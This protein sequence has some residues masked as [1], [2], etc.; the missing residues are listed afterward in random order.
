M[1]GR[2]SIGF[3]D[4]T[5]LSFAFDRVCCDSFGFFWCETGAL[6]RRSVHR[7][8]PTMP[9][10]ALKRYHQGDQRPCTRRTLSLAGVKLA[11]LRVERDVLEWYLN[12]GSDWH[13]RLDEALCKAAGK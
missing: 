13:D 6:K 1:S 7:A 9:D 3:V 5:K 2:I 11:S 8:A 10:A 4:F 12:C